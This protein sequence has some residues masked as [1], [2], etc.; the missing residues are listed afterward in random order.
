[1][2]KHIREIYLKTAILIEPFQQKLI[3]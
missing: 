3:Q 2:P 1:M